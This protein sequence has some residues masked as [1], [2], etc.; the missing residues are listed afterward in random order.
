MKEKPLRRALAT[1]HSFFTRPPSPLLPSEPEKAEGEEAQERQA[2]PSLHLL[3]WREFCTK[4][5]QVQ[6]AAILKA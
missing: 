6:K 2:L 4:L 1:S 3:L 5:F